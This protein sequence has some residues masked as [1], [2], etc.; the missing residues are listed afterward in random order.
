MDGSHAAM[1]DLKSLSPAELL[2]LHAAVSEELRERGV[3]GSSDNP[4]A[5]LRN[6]CSAAPS[7][8][9]RRAG[10]HSDHGENSKRI[11]TFRRRA[12]AFC[13][14]QRKLAAL[15]KKEAAERRA[16]ARLAREEHRRARTE[17]PELDRQEKEIEQRRAKLIVRKRQA[18]TFLLRS[19]RFPSRP[20]LL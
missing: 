10:A 6:I 2:N 4:A 1:P 18:L 8:G 13:C 19:R 7:S 14:T 11:P 20:G 3:L 17:L 9:S 12:S 5:I 16:E 15:H